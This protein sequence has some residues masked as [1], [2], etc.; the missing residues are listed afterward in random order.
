[1]GIVDQQK[2]RFKITQKVLVQ[3]LSGLVLAALLFCT[4][5]CGNSDKISD[6]AVIVPGTDAALYTGFTIIGKEQ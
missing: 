5:G 3:L 6:K 1:M 2:D 4:A